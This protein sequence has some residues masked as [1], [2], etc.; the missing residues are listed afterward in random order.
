MGQ[1]AP[2]DSNAINKWVTLGDKISITHNG[3]YF[4]YTVKNQPIGANT[5][6]IQSIK[7]DWKKQFV[8]ANNASFS[9]NNKCVIF[10]MQDTLNFL[11]L[12]TDSI[13][14]ISNVSSC[15]M[16]ATSNGTTL[17]A[18]RLNNNNRELVLKNLTTGEKKVFFDVADYWF[19]SDG[20]VL[21]IKI[22]MNLVNASS[23]LL[24]WLDI[25]EGHCY[26]IWKGKELYCFN[27]DPNANQIA[28]IAPTDSLRKNT[29]SLWH[30]KKGQE[31]ARILVNEETVGINR[32]LTVNN[33]LP[34]FST[35]GDYIF[36]TMTDVEVQPK[37]NNNVK[38][39]IW[40]Y[41]DVIVQS[42]QLN[43]KAVFDCAIR[44]G[45]S[46]IIIT[47]NMEQIVVTGKSD[48]IVISDN[49]SLLTKWWK[50]NADSY[51]L[52]SLKDKTK[53]FL[54]RGV[55]VRITF[56][57]SPGGRYIVYFNEQL[58]KYFCYDL[59]KNISRNISQAI[60]QPLDDEYAR[61]ENTSIPVGIA[62][63][64]AGDSSILIY[65][66]Y[67]IWKVN[68]SNTRSPENF[69]NGYGKEHRIKFRLVEEQL[70]EGKAIDGSRPLLLTAFTTL[71]KHNGFFSKSLNNKENPKLLYSG[72]CSIYTTYQQY[73][74]VSHYSFEVS[75]KPVK[76]RDSDIWIVKRMTA[77]EAPNYF[78]TRDFINYY[79]LSNLQPQTKYNWLTAELV[80]W[81]QPNGKR[82]QGILY[83]PENFDPKKKYPIIFNY[84]EQLTCRLFEFPQP[85]FAEA[86]INIP[87]FVSR[88]YLV[89]TPDYHQ[90][91]ANLSDRT[92]GEN[93]YT[94]IISA[95]T[96]LSKK[97]WVDKNKMGLNGHSHAGGLTN[98]VIAHTNIFKAAIE[99]A[100]ISDAVSSYLDGSDRQYGT[101]I[102]QGRM[103]ATLWSRQDL[104]IKASPV[105]RADKITT[106]LL[107]MHN[108]L[109]EAVPWTQGLELFMALRRLDKKV[110]ML[111]Y[112]GEDHTLKRKAA[113]D[114]T[115]R[116]T[117]FFDHFLKGFPQPKWMVVGIPT[118]L[119]GIELG[120]EMY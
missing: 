64:M 43:K 113:E 81:R 2:I 82:L 8:G 54:T 20:H 14:S 44:A 98:Y 42:E 92:N 62:G 5:L 67:D 70:L 53:K 38:L 103:G 94:S 31:H 12:G 45:E 101:E 1:K 21:L 86:T 109:D 111:Q 119:K 77:S 80:N 63:W 107:I 49:K 13:Q 84:Y 91:I 17:L 90:S 22:T 52:F 57:F 120:Y 18:Y 3:N 35:N 71:N 6:V 55:N 112:D 105:Y 4:L 61:A 117:Q 108:K 106:P 75:M 89:F 95:I 34:K 116:I 47:K 60:P 118:R 110:W 27:F 9:G 51:Y 10:Q 79:R 73:P 25:K 24:M 87:W 74:N 97:P 16:L 76:A 15:K 36:F 114:F 23:T 19:D 93:L 30:Y 83:K 41:K 33:D 11:T 66:N 46:P 59:L 58:K 50:R 115:I 56:S 68:M 72:P 40:N 37:N 102:G 48:N 39:D 32:T 78:Y 26:S 29:N 28:F 88:G 85:R 69:T 7:T 100:G 99:A 65:D 104:Y 96:S